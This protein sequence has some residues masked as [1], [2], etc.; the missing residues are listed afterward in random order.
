MKKSKNKSQ[1][2]MAVIVC[3]ALIIA[4]IIAGYINLRLVDEDLTKFLV[5]KVEI[6]SVNFKQTVDYYLESL[7]IFYSGGS[8]S[9]NFNE[10]TL[11]Q[12]QDATIRRLI[13]LANFLSDGD[14]MTFDETKVSEKLLFAA[15]FDFHG[16]LI[17]HSGE[18]SSSVKNKLF[19]MIDHERTIFT[20]IM[21]RNKYTEEPFIVSIRN[22]SGNVISICLDDRGLNFWKLREIV[23]SSLD[24]IIDTEN[25]L[26][27]EIYDTDDT[28]LGNTEDSDI[29]LPPISERPLWQKIE[30]AGETVFAVTLPI[31]FRDGSSAKL[32]TIISSQDKDTIYNNIYKTILTAIILLVTMG[33]F[34]VIFVFRNQR[35]HL[36]SIRY[37]EKELE[38][39]ERLS[40]MGKLAAAVAHEIRN[41]LNAISMASQRIKSDG[42]EPVIKIMKDEIS[43]LNH[44]V[45]D[46]LNLSRTEKINFIR[47]DI[48]ET[49]YEFYALAEDDAA[50]YSVRLELELP[51][52]MLVVSFDPYRFRQVLYN[53]LR[54]AFEASKPGGTVS[55][56]AEKVKNKTAVVKI[57]DSG[58]GI[59]KENIPKLF[60]PDFTTKD[61]GIGL[62]LSIV[63]E[64]IR[65]HGGTINIS[66]LEGHGT[67]VE[68]M[69]PLH[70][71]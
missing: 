14:Q 30:T 22:A 59:T 64:I 11:Y 39:S 5:K 7:D 57:S 56:K 63:Y 67:T 24:Y 38:R 41:P 28:L 66:S 8:S 52:D 47:K 43:R 58:S 21:D 1:T 2:V 44:T 4:G 16:K 35:K 6:V 12:F 61:K 33:M 49:L 23:S 40:A 60:Q 70:A 9:F 45:E 20:N 10:E 32:T 65:S 68:L 18:I 3:N 27:A 19:D 34:S 15:E 51:D 69:F 25:F 46:F 54:N 37:M 53:L 62:G 71:D 48:R 29:V 36:S 17:R 13:S 26:Y 50:Q 42:S 55:I 31:E